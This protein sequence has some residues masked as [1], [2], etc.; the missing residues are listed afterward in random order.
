[1][2]WYF[3]NARSPRLKT[4]L[5][6]MGANVW[7]PDVVKSKLFVMYYAFDGAIRSRHRRGDCSEPWGPWTDQ[8]AFSSNEIGVN[9]SIDPAVF[10]IRKE[11][12]HDLG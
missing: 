12:T 7:A 11:I 8:E 6:T 9:N 5:G 1:M 3:K 4:E 10:P 2:H